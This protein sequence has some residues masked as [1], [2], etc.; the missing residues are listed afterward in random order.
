MGMLVS[1]LAM[2]IGKILHSLYSAKPESAGDAALDW[3]LMSPWLSSASIAPSIPLRCRQTL[4]RMCL[5]DAEKKRV[6][7]DENR[8][9]SSARELLLPVLLCR[10]SQDCFSACRSMTIRV[11]DL[12]RCD[13]RKGDM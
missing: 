3:S 8:L 2:Q 1:L 10:L 11:E 5:R 13:D 4:K 9:F 6:L 7:V 12:F